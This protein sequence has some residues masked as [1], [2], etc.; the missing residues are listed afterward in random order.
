MNEPLYGLGLGLGLRKEPS[1]PD[2][3]KPTDDIGR[4]PSEMYESS[5]TKR[6]FKIN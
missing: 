4:P 6:C 2:R 5:L 3:E 1:N